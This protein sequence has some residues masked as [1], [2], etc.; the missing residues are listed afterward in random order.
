M[1]KALSLIVIIIFSMILS[2]AVFAD[3]S[4]DIVK[5]KDGTVYKGII[6][7]EKTDDYI[8]IKLLDDTIILID[9][10]DIDTQQ[11][12]NSNSSTGE[13]VTQSWSI[14]GFE[15]GN[16]WENTSLSD[17]SLVSTYM[18]SI[19][20]NITAYTFWDYNDIGLFVSDFFLFPLSQTISYDGQ[21]ITVSLDEYS[22]LMHL[23]LYMGPGFRIKM[24]EDVHLRFGIGPGYSQLTGIGDEVFVQAYNIGFGGD[25]GVTFD[26]SRKIFFDIGCK[27]GYDFLNHTSL[28]TPEIDS[29]Q[30]A[31]DYSMFRIQPTIS[32][33]FKQEIV[34]K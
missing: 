25:F 32:I 22:L 29:S 2:F 13:E 7:E 34:R 10:T 31:S 6:F 21:S 17:G 24:A 28:T 4:I 16:F 5:L 9:Y 11:Q 30:W 8:K 27:Y 14:I 26:L 1:K 33:G 23:G 3:T 15:Q 19:G 18:I 12:N 20:V